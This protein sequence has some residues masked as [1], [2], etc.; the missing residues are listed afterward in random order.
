NVARRLYT[1]S[2][3]PSETLSWAGKGCPQKAEDKLTETLNIKSGERW[4]EQALDDGK[5]NLAITAKDKVEVCQKH[6]QELWNNKSTNNPQIFPW[7][8]PTIT[9]EQAIYLASP[10]TMQ[11]VMD[12]IRSS[13][14]GK[15]PDP[16]G[17]PSE[18]Y[19]IMKMKIVLHLTNMFN[20]I[21]SGSNPPHTW[22]EAHIVQI[23]KKTE[24]ID[25]VGNWH[26]IM[27]E[28]C[29]LKIFSRVLS[30]H[31]Q[32]VL[33]TIIHESQTGFV[34]GWRLFES[35]LTIDSILQVQDSN[36][37]A[38]LTVDNKEAQIEIKQ[39]VPQGDPI[40]PLLFIIALE[41]LMAAAR[42]EIE[43]SPTVMA[44]YITWPMQM[45]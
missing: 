1:T 35:A 15:A 42:V 14:R 36:G 30:N 7:H 28:N 26:P 4:I 3:K 44:Q 33:D 41:P 25:Q 11:E 8:C 40:A 37:I 2:A 12:S 6:L 43:G 21:L 45:T 31:F 20:E 24:N 10:I 5:G 16:D 38:K 9:Q 13:P 29:D 19:H 22:S 23:P 18:F 34:R 17:L 32:E 39:G 27:L